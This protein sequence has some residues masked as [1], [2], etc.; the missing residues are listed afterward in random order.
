MNQIFKSSPS[1]TITFEE[2]LGWAE[3]KDFFKNAVTDVN[4][5][6]ALLDRDCKKILYLYSFIYILKRYKR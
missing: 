2:F 5:L 4:I 1:Q 3:K 6:F